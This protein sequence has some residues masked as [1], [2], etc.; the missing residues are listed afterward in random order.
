M[1][2]CEGKRLCVYHTCTYM[3]MCMCM[4]AKEC[5]CEC[6]CMCMRAKECVCVCVN[7]CVSVYVHESER[8]CV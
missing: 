3:C 2:V 4:R 1:C 6:V 5:V 7:V 8:V